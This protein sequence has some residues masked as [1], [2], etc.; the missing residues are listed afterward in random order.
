[1]K[2]SPP[3]SADLLASHL[4]ATF[5]DWYVKRWKYR[6]ADVTPDQ[7]AASAVRMMRGYLAVPAL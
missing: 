7:F 4:M 1:M 3:G 6:A 2:L 5:Q